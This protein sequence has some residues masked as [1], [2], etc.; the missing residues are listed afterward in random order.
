MFCLSMGVPEISII[1][2]SGLTGLGKKEKNT[3]LARHDAIL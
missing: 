2:K 1:D 3:C